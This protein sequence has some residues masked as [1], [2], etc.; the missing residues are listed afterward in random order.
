MMT[1]VVTKI[2]WVSTDDD[3]E[4]KCTVAASVA[5][6]CSLL[7]GEE[8][9]KEERRTANAAKNTSPAISTTQMQ[10]DMQIDELTLRQLHPSIRVRIKGYFYDINVSSLCTMT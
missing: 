10:N 2:C 6:N 8:R 3:D 5:P 9:R 4:D 7:P 1:V